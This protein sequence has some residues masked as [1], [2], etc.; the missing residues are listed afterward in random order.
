VAFGLLA[1]MQL[2]LIAGISVI[3][4]AL[5]AVGREF[6]TGRSGLALVTT[7]YGL[8]FGGLLM[9]GGRI[10]DLAGHRRT[11]LAGVLVFGAGSVAAAVAPGF[12]W[13]VAARFG[14]GV[15][16][17]L[18]APAALA[19]L[20]AIYPE[21]A[22]RARMLAIWGGVNGI[23]ATLGLL[24]SGLVVTYVSWRWS[25]ALPAA[26]AAVVAAS[27]R[28]VLPVPPRPERPERPGRLDVLS[29]VLITLGISVLS[30]GFL[31]AGERPWTAPVVYAPIAAGA[32]VLAAFFVRESR[33]ADPLLPPSLLA[34]RRRATG[35]LGIFLMAGGMAT[36]L[37]LLSLFFQQE[38]GLSPL[39]TSAA[40]LPYGLAQVG[41][42]LVAGRL[43]G[44]FGPRAVTTTGLLL[45]A[46]ALLLIGTGVPPVLYAAL[47][48]FAVA[49]ALVFAGSMVAAV[50]DVPT[51]Q[52]GVAGGV[53]NTAMETGPTVGL[54]VLISLGGLA[55]PVAA[56]AFLATAALAMITLRKPEGR[57][58]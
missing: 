38:R 32:A 27:G 10:A 34:A 19:L 36:T 18:V 25:F 6:G 53:V 1:G 26:V 35:V 8:A 23:G 15:G 56:A 13:L 33:S 57:P 48:A 30:H 29:A 7:A 3:L 44:R 37:F 14:Q 55:F 42:G 41:S 43:V 45:V 58:R 52:A 39:Q 54:A 20:G 51:A 24:L 49:S 16:A 17:A 47:P 40:F 12:G 5:P 21:P 4:V 28:R 9:L 2:V 50:D 31:Q 22:R 46:G 11:F